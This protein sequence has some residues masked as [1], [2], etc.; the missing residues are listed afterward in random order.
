MWARSPPGVL[1]IHFT[2]MA[3]LSSIVERRIVVPEVPGATPGGQTRIRVRVVK[4]ADL[5][6]AGRKARV[7]SIPTEC[8]ERYYQW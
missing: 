7:G 6:S 4:E 8:I 2:E 1:T 3:G 5:R